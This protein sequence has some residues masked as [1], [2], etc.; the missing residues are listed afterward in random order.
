MGK[1][2]LVAIDTVTCGVE[3]LTGEF[4]YDGSQ[5]EILEMQ[6]YSAKPIMLPISQI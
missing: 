2:T 6:K 4:T 5:G 3:Q 1:H